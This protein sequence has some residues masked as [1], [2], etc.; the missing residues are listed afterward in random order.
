ML[1]LKRHTCTTPCPTLRPT[2]WPTPPLPL[3]LA[4]ILEFCTDFLNFC[5]YL[6]TLLKKNEHKY[7]SI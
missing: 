1:N 7:V 4:I 3:L 6:L 2:P 5:A